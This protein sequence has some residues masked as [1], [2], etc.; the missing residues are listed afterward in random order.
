MAGVGALIYAVWKV[1]HYR[2]NQF[3]DPSMAE[4]CAALDTLVA[5]VVIGAVSPA[6]P[7]GMSQVFLVADLRAAN[8]RH[9]NRFGLRHRPLDLSLAAYASPRAL[10]EAAVVCSPCAPGQESLGRRDRVDRNRRC[11]SDF[12]SEVSGPNPTKIVPCCMVVTRNAQYWRN[13]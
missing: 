6:A 13:C 4:F 12:P 7:R 5:I 3:V 11:G 2:T 1:Y 8:G 10:P 9:C